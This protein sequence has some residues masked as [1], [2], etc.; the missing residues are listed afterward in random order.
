MFCGLS[1]PSINTPRGIFGMN[2][3]WSPP[4]T[5]DAPVDCELSPSCPESVLDTTRH[6]VVVFMYDP[7]VVACCVCES[8]Q[9]DPKIVLWTSPKLWKINVYM[10][11]F[12][13]LLPEMGSF[14]PDPSLQGHAMM[15]QMSGQHNPAGSELIGPELIEMLCDPCDATP[16]DVVRGLFSWILRER[17]AALHETCSAV[18]VMI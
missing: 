4:F 2:S 12:R 14:K 18:L 16:V 1:F 8:N 9:R 11:W 13:C 3:W 7:G 5:G 6:S 15:S 10:I 17:T